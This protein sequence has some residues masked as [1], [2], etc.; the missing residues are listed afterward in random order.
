[1]S[2]KTSPGEGSGRRAKPGRARARGTRGRSRPSFAPRPGA[3]PAGVGQRGCG[4]GRDRPAPA[5]GGRPAR[6]PSRSR[7]PR[8]LSR[9]RGRESRP[10]RGDRPLAAGR[11]SE[12]TTHT[13]HSARRDR[14]RA[15]R[16]PRRACVAQSVDRASIAHVRKGLPIPL[17]QS[18][19]RRAPRRPGL[20]NRA[21][22]RSHRL[23]G[24]RSDANGEP[25]SP[26]VGGGRHPK[27]LVF[28]R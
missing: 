6:R 16:R 4:G 18:Y 26:R 25:R 27:T 5:R 7:R 10:A 24:S 20:D 8:A 3:A 22:S 23:G 9:A 19:K 11:D 28:G 17:D 13:R 14:D 1:M 12:P 2:K 21:G 15:A